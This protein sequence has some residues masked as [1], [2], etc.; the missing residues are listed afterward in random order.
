MPALSGIMTVDTI[1]LHT[2][3]EHEAEIKH[4]YALVNRGTSEKHFLN[5]MPLCLIVMQDGCI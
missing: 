3:F 1:T 4:F 5:P 2:S